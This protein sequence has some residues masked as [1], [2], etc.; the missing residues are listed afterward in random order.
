MPAAKALA[1]EACKP[2]TTAPAALAV[3]RLLKDSADTAD[4]WTW[5]IAFVAQLP[6]D[7]AS[8]E[9]VRETNAFALANA[10]KLIEAIAKL[11]ELMILSGPTPERLGLLGGRYKRL[12]AKAATPAERLACLNKSIDAYERGMEIDLNKYYCSSNLPR[13]YLQRNRKGDRERAVAVSQIVVAACERAKKRKEADEWLRPTLLGAAFD[14]GDADKAEELATEV[15]AEGAARWKLAT[16]MS[17]LKSTVLLVQ[18][19]DTKNRLTTVLET[20]KT[21]VA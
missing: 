7:I 5:L 20:L 9:E 10:G 1:D 21:A 6:A 18:D 16:T 8:L 2:P 15:L 12:A 4:D 3:I 11:E 19:P 13:L 17:D 14:A